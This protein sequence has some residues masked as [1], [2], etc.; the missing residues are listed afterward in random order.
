LFLQFACPEV[1]IILSNFLFTQGDAQRHMDTLHMAAKHVSGE[2]GA[3]VK[4][5]LGKATR[6]DMLAWLGSVI[7]GNGERAKMQMD[8]RV[9]P[10]VPCV[11]IFFFF[12]LL[13]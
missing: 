12:Y 10:L 1:T 7:E 6:E 9:R 4:S 8:L 2:L 13:L 5:L 11:I 3:I